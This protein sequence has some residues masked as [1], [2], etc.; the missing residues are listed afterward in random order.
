MTELLSNPFAS[1]SRTNP[2]SLSLHLLNWSLPSV[3]NIIKKTSSA[4][5]GGIDSLE[6]LLLRQAEEQMNL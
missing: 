6:L 3:L 2:R 1:M 4:D 5:Y